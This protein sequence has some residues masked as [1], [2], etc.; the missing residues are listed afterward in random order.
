M[1]LATAAAP[2]ARQRGLGWEHYQTANTFG[3]TGRC[4]C[5]RLCCGKARAQ[6]FGLL[7]ALVLD[8]LE[9]C[10]E[11]WRSCFIFGSFRGDTAHISLFGLQQP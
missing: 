9:L 11:P 2:F 6:V 3:I 10:R 5:T 8:S 1:L 7:F 4:S